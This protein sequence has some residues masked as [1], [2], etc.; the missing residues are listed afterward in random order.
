MFKIRYLLEADKSFWFALDEHLSEKE[1]E[2]KI[3]DKRGY[4]IC[5]DDKP[6]GVMRYNLI[7]DIVPFLTFIELEESYRGKG[8]GS[9]AMEHW[10]KEMQSLGHELVMTST[11]P[12]EQAQFFYRKIG[13]KDSG[14]LLLTDEPLEIFFMKRFG[15]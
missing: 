10:E 14:C 9:Q 15:E 1:F 3:R 12:H 7:F 2:L 6:I 8:I 13:Y 4:I 5:D 11:Q